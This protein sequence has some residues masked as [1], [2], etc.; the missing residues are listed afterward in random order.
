MT[1]ADSDLTPPEED[2]R[3]AM[4]TGG[5]VNL[6]KNDPQAD[7]PS[8]GVQWGP[9]RTIRAEVLA[10]L[11]TQVT[12]SQRPRALRLAGAR[13]TGK[14]DL[15]AAEL[16]CPVMLV[17]CWFAEP[18]NVGEA[19]VASLRLPGCHL[20][21]LQAWQLTTK[22][23]LG[24]NYGFTAREL[25]LAGARIGG[26]LDVS[27]A[28]L[29]NPNATALN[30]DGL[31]VGHHLLCRGLAVEGMVDLR[32][33]HI[34][35]QLNVS[36]AILNNPNGSALHGN[37]LVVDQDMLS[38]EKFVAHGEV[39]LLG[40][41]IGGQLSLT[42]AILN[43]PSRIALNG[44]QLTVGQSVHL[45]GD[46]TAHGEVHLV[47]AR[48]GGEFDLT[49]TLVNPNGTA[50]KADGLI[51]EQSI[52]CY[53]GLTIKGGVILMGAHIS[54]AL[55][56]AGVIVSNPNGIALHLQDAQIGTLMLHPVARPGAINL[57]NAQLGVLDDNPATW[58]N[59]LQLRGCTYDAL[60]ERTPVSVG[61]RLDWLSRD[62][63]GYAPQPYE[64]IT[65]VYRR[66]GREEDARRVAIAKQRDRRRTLPIPGRAAS[67][68]LDVLV[69][70][71]YRPW[72]AGLWLLGLVRAGGWVFDLAHPTRLIA[73]RPAGQRPAFHASLYALDL[74]LPIGDLNYQ[75]VWIPQGWARW[76]WLAWILAGWVLTIAVVAALSG[77]LK[78]D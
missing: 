8:Q 50:L 49:G 9:E 60:Y 51:V 3:K 23:N 72:L 6:R 12:G 25:M 24:L 68:L 16:V 74:L 39:H 4:S 21:G 58:P 13:V 31:T 65:T 40:A 14:L 18:V 28:T 22:G 54:G 7:D 43:N 20:P 17:A 35:G 10:N 30:G 47:N 19:T 78:R 61:Q 46:F 69:N 77:I 66:A 5:W 48:I 76:C 15:E 57:S 29:V 59:Q 67:L 73:T 32:R 37:R 34:G 53:G 45:R 52:F 64:Q 42:G 44:N 27:G 36:G 63:E 41:R 38:S 11:L 26:Q 71:G 55:G 56:F 2:L 75:G 33:A 62:P 1:L 70:Y